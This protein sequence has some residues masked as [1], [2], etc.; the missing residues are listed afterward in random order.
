M[1]EKR[2]DPSRN[3]RVCGGAMG[4]TGIERVGRDATRLG[5]GPYTR[6]Q[7]Q[8]VC[9]SCKTIDWVPKRASAEAR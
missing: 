2:A 3:C 4:R 9:E 6:A 1:T 8:L 7:E 5:K